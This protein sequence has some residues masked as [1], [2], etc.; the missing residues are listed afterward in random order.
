MKRIEDNTLV[1]TVDVRANKH[2]MKQAVKK[3]YDIVV[4]KVSTLIRPDGEKKAYVRLAPDYDA[5]GRRQR[6]FT[7]V[8]LPGKSHAWRSLVGC[9]PWGR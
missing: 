5:L 6:H 2:Q 9:S 4:A 8:L 3:L 7:P 1:L